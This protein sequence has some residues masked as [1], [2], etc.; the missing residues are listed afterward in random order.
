[1]QLFTF[2]STNWAVDYTYIVLVVHHF[3]SAPCTISSV[4]QS[5]A[6]LSLRAGFH[7]SDCTYVWWTVWTPHKSLLEVSAVY[8]TG[9]LWRRNCTSALVNQTVLIILPHYLAYQHYHYSLPVLLTLLTGF[10]TVPLPLC[11]LLPTGPYSNA[12]ISRSSTVA[13]AYVIETERVSLE[14]AYDRLKKS[15]PAIQPNPGFMSQLAD[16][17][18]RLEIQQWISFSIQ[19]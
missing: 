11:P 3:S 17:Q 18:E 1:M 4:C 19:L 13:L 5:S 7:V 12:G 15:R 8:Q 16:F 2:P 6:Y 9:S 10:S 14:L